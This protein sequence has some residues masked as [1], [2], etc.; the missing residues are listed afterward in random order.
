MFLQQTRAAWTQDDQSWLGS[1]HGTDATRTI[2]LDSSA[3][4]KATHY[5][6]GFFPSGL[7]VKPTGSAGKYGPAANSDADGVFLFT[8]VAAAPEGDD[9]DVIA[10]ALDHGRI[11]VSRLPIAISG[12]ALT[13]PHFV[14]QS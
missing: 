3:F 14:F 10:A 8:A 1:A 4:T 9:Y 6:H 7:Y 11:V 2:T 5:P 12:A 13:N